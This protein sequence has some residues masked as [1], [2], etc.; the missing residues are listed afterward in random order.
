MMAYL[1]DQACTAAD[2]RVYSLTRTA[3]D[4]TVLDDYGRYSSDGVHLYVV[5]ETSR[6]LPLSRNQETPSTATHQAILAN[7]ATVPATQPPT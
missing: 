3:A 5:L 4:V 7:R 1:V 2:S 6:L